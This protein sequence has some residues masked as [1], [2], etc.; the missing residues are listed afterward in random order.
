MAGSSSA[1]VVTAA[2]PDRYANDSCLQE[3][4]KSGNPLR[5]TVLAEQPSFNT[6]ELLKADLGRSQS[7]FERQLWTTPTT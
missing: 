7:G 1:A 3:T 6:L 2:A 5:M 4:V